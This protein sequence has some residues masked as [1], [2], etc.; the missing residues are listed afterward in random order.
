MTPLIVRG[1]QLTSWSPLMC[2][3]NADVKLWGGSHARRAL[4]GT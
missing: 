2:V 1:K 4:E 3:D